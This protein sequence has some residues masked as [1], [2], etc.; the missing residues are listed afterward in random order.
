MRNSVVN[1]RDIPKDG[2]DFVIDDPAVWQE[3]IREFGLDVRIVEP[4]VFR[5][6]VLPGDDGFLLRGS[7]RGLVGMPCDR[8]AE[9]T[10][11]RIDA[12]FDEFEAFPQEEEQGA[13]LFSDSV[14]L[15]ADG[16]WLLDLGALAW[17]EFAMALPSK[18]LC[19]EDCKGVCPVC[20]KNRNAGGCACAEAGGHPGLAV[21]RGLKIR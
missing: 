13:G 6:A 10:L 11:C 16:G 7:I 12:T 2:R 17:E 19:R 21:L 4:I 20:G 8:C 5:T 9:E 15:P 18:P 1:S 14:L 3:P